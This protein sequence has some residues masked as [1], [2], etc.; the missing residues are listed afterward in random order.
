MKSTKAWAI[1]FHPGIIESMVAMDNQKY[2]SPLCIFKTP[3]QAVSWVQEKWMGNPD[4]T[5]IVEVEI[6]PVRRKP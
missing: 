5:K 3:V 1:Y 4:L 6:R 2:F